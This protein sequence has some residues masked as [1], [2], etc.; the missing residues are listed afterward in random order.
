[1]NYREMSPAVGNAMAVLL[2]YLEKLQGAPPKR[3]F[4]T[5]RQVPVR[6]FPTS[7]SHFLLTSAVLTSGSNY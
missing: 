2:A 6:N 3:F 7:Q 4:H 5:G 1:M